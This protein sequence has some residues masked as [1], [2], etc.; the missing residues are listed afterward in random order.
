MIYLDAGNSFIKIATHT[1]DI[2]DDSG[3]LIQENF[4]NWMVHLRA[5]HADIEKVISLL[6]TEILTSMPILACSVVVDV[7]RRLE[8]A[9]GSRIQFLS[10]NKILPGTLDYKTVDTLGMDRYLACLGAWSLSKGNAVIVVDAGTATTIDWMNNEG[11]FKG[12]VITPGLSVF[13]KG[14]REFAPALPEVPRSIPS[15][16]PPRSTREAL[17][18]GIAG[19]YV[20]MVKAHIHR[21][22]DKSESCS[23]WITGGDAEILAQIRE[24]QI[25]Y[26]PNLV[27]EG[28][29]AWQQ[30]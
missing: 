11:V 24:Y 18:W 13:E 29:R 15:E 10:H 5:R 7:Q 2:V 4:D 3:T 26:H 21:F 14:L 6:Q 25:Q 30:R 27:F 22:A 8:E 23:I 12:G 16:W 20:E 28:L 19:S 17:Q 1:G 9:L